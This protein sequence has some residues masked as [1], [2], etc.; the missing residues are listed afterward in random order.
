MDARPKTTVNSPSKMQSKNSTLAS[1]A[2]PPIQMQMRTKI[3]IKLNSIGH[4][5]PVTTD[6]ISL[7]EPDESEPNLYPLRLTTVGK[8]KPDDPCPLMPSA[9]PPLF[10]TENNEP[11]RDRDKVWRLESERR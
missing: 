8:C 5:R 1:A 7:F 11:V 4:L 9:I 3:D 10:L 2:M 6:F